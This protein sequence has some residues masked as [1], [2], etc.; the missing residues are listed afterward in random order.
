MMEP[1]TFFWFKKW[2]G[3]F[4]DPLTAISVFALLTAVIFALLPKRFRQWRYPA[5]VSTFALLWIL[6]T[7]AVSF[8]LMAPIEDSG[9]IGIFN[10]RTMEADVIVVLGCGH[11]E[12]DYV[13]LSSRYQSCSMRR[14]VHAILLHRESGLPIVFSG[15]K[16]PGNRYSEAHYNRYLAL[17]L[18]VYIEN[19]FLS[20]G[21]IDT[22]GEAVV[23]AETWESKDVVL[24]TSASHMKRA[25]AYMT[26]AGIRVHPSPTDHSIKVRSIDLV[27]IYAY[28][29][30]WSGL[31][32][33]GSAIY[34]RL[35][36]L[37]QAWF[38]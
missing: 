23:L 18:G 20:L 34:E 37:S 28:L 38:E 5:F 9:R 31:K 35:G 33:T 24:V 36:L 19:T 15:G 13:P 8:F 25:M 4:T 29:P 12:S 26:R 30:R 21:A 3:V 32:R 10:F 11:I 16:M 1:S 14:V 7:P 22:A 17:K 6:S 27:S 2:V